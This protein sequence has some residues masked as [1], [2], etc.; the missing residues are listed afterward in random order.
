MLDDE[1]KGPEPISH[2]EAELKRKLFFSRTFNRYKV[3]KGKMHEHHKLMARV[4]VD[5][6]LNQCDHLGCSIDRSLKAQI[7][8]AEDNF[9]LYP[10]D[11]KPV[12]DLV[13]DELKERT[14]D[15]RRQVNVARE[16]LEA[17]RRKYK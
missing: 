4:L 1:I 9:E 2:A 13:V 16:K 8:R 3:P 17:A 5:R 6:S 15:A 10:M 12:A 7:K 11:R 14:F